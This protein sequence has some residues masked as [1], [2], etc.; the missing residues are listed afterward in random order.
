MSNF[1]LVPSIDNL[2]SSST[3]NI[4]ALNLNSLFQYLYSDSKIP[5]RKY[6]QQDKVD[7]EM[8]AHKRC[9]HCESKS[10]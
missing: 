7:I 6:S 1:L 9:S 3:P 5:F 8:F 4:C 2:S 10:I